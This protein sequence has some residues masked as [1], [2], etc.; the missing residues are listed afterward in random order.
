MMAN[1]VKINSAPMMSS[2]AFRHRATVQSTFCI[3][4]AVMRLGSANAARRR[5]G[6]A[7][8]GERRPA[9]RRWSRA[10]KK[11][12]KHVS[13]KKG[14]TA[15]KPSHPP[16]TRGEVKQSTKGCPGLPSAGAAGAV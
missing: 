16:T 9:A 3:D 12:E 5:C 13:V 10:V 8:D 15:K 7:A 2:I 6:G 14:E 1:A 11:H 4:G